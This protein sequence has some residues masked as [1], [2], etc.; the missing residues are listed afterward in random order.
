MLTAA[1]LGLDAR[2]FAATV[3]LAASC[4]FIAPL[5]PAAM[6]VYGPGRYRF[7]DYF[8]VGLP[9]TLLVL[10]I[11]LFM[12][13]RIWPLRPDPAPAAAIAPAAAGTE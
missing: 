3:T 13:P 7:R 5:E 6:L 2:P 8:R 1:R 4:S 11:N 9:L 12:V 10:V